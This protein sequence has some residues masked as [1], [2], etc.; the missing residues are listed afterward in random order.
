MT[1]I[2][3]IGAWGG[4][5]ISRGRSTPPTPPWPSTRLCLGWVAFTILPFDI[6]PVLAR[7]TGMVN[8]VRAERERCA[9][10]ADRYAQDMKTLSGHERQVAAW[11][12]REIR[13]PDE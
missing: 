9:R 12:A 6:D 4:F 2:V 10:I 13:R 7:L 8:A 3:N 1:I 5:Y 11:I